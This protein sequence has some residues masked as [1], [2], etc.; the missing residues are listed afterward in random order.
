MKGKK[1][2]ARL[3]KLT[4]LLTTLT[5]LS[6]S[7]VSLPVNAVST[8]V[9]GNDNFSRYPFGSDPG[10]LRAAVP[11]FAAGVVYQQVYSESSFSGPVTIT[12]IAF[13]SKA[14]ITSGPGT[15]TYNFDL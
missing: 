5:L 7:F 4:L 8:T 10:H 14:Q 13:A 15:A 12:Q 9:G 6:L 11:G 1:K 2:M 3:T